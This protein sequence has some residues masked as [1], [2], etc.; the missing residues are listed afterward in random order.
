MIAHASRSIVFI[1]ALSLEPNAFGHEQVGLP[2]TYSS[3]SYN[4]E[5]DDLV[6][7]EVRIIPTNQGNKAI[8]QVAEGDAGRIYIVD[9]TSDG[10]D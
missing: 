8:V 2:G 7:Y 10:K 4:S 9:V 3:L 1:T 5:S 6:G